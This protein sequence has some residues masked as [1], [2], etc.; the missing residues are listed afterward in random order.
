MFSGGGNTNVSECNG[1]PL[2]TTPGVQATIVPSVNGT[3][4]AGKFAC[5][6][7]PNDL[8]PIC[9]S[10][11]NGEMYD[12]CG[13]NTCIVGNK[14]QFHNCLTTHY[15]G[16]LGVTDMCSQPSAAGVR[17]RQVGVVVVLGLALS[18]VAAV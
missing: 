5:Y 11:L 1:V 10:Q 12:W 14:E 18:V 8:T 15:N 2:P 3:L 7:A 4:P 9:C 6:A 16:S 17:S 13:W